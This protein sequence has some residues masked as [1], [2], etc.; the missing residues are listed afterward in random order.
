MICA[1]NKNDGRGFCSG[2]LDVVDNNE[3]VDIAA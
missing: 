2:H 3:L 1:K